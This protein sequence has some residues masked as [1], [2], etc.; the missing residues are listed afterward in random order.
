VVFNGEIYNYKELAKSYG[1]TNLSSTS[2]TEVLIHLLDGQGV[3]A[4]IQ[5]L[6]GMFAIAIVDTEADCLYLTRD[7]AGIKPLFYGIVAEGVVMASQFDQVFKHNWFCKTLDLQPEIVK[8]YFG[9]GYMQAPNTIYKSI[10]QVNPGELQQIERQGTVSKK[11]LV[12]F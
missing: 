10:F 7:F 11:T 4:T 12:S 9:F 6:N 2:D 8:E 5:L 3:E 1:L